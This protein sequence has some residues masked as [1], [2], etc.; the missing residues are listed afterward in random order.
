[1]Q[2]LAGDRFFEILMDLARERQESDMLEGLEKKGFEHK[3]FQSKRMD[4][5][6]SVQFVMALEDR[7]EKELGRRIEFSMTNLSYEQSV[8]E[9]YAATNQLLGQT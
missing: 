4:S 2:I 7:L 8:L 3:L 6:G 9:L 1:M 5:L